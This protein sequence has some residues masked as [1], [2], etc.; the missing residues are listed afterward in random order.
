MGSPQAELE[1][2]WGKQKAKRF[3]NEKNIIPATHFYLIW[4]LGYET[5]MAIYPKI[6]H[7]FIIKQVSGWCGCNSKLSLWEEN[8][9]NEYPQCGCKNKKFKA[10][11]KMHG[12]GLP[13]PALSVDRECHGCARQGKHNS[14]TG[15]DD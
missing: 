15:T 2:C 13:P 9:S 11:N 3:F 8:V 6:F 14:S 12:P 1:D 5:A 10:P 7:S 4:W